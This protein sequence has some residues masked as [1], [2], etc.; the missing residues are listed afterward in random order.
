M[1]S[2]I[3]SIR[4]IFGQQRRHLVPLYQRP[5]VWEQE[6]QWEPLWDDLRSLAERILAGGKA[7]PHFLGAIVL[8]QVRNPTGYVES[9]WV[10]DGQQRLTTIQIVLEA[11]SDLCHAAGEQEFASALHALTRNQNHMKEPEDVEFKVWPTNVDRDVFRRVMRAESREALLDQFDARPDATSIDSKIGDAYLFFTKA[12]LDW[13]ELDSAGFKDRLSAL[14]RAIPDLV[15]MV[16]IDLGPDDDA[17]LIFETLNARG[18]PLL[19]ADLVKNFLFHRAQIHGYDIEP[20]Y[21]EYWL[22]FDEENKYWRKEIGA[23]RVRRA[24]IDVFLQHYL[25]L[26]RRDEV[27]PAHLYDAFREHAE[28]MPGDGVVALLAELR[29][30]SRIFTSFE[31]DG[32]PEAERTFFETLEVLETMTVY[33]ILM[34]AMLRHG[35]KRSQIHSIM[36]D[37][38][39]FLVRRMVCQLTTKNYNRLFLDLLVAMLDGP[40]EGDAGRVRKLL[41]A[42]DGP[43]TRWPTDEE[44]KKAWLDDPL[45]ERIKRARLRMVLERLDVAAH[46]DKSE[47]VKIGGKITIEH[48]MPQQ[49]RA[50]WPGV[51][52]GTDDEAFRDRLLHSIGNLTLLN[53]KLNPAVSNAGWTAKV[54]QIRKF[55]KLELNRYFHDQESWDEEEIV[56]RGKVL[57]ADARRIWRRP[58]SGA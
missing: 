33:P 26:A 1:D 52:G 28:S 50:H 56:R 42:Q 44:F 17:Q 16:V 48:L 31:S 36:Q 12:M 18:T 25:T 55:T 30:Y 46:S 54:K 3:L 27:S 58:A 32:A 22:P 21:Q 7:R 15:R 51:E 10:I 45:Y 20:L 37:L 24:R 39:S 13:L 19:P 35:K 40:P 11:F 38:E 2:G 23:G 6:K 34:S 47:D 9:R 53:E 43:S 41:L 57:F 8:D 14:F 5:Y 4:T 49:W 29:D